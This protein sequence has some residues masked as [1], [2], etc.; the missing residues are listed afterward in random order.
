VPGTGYVVGNTLSVPIGS[1]LTIA[2]VTTGG[3]ATVT[4]TNAGSLA[5]GAVPTTRLRQQPSPASAPA[6]ILI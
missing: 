6:R 1:V 2:T 5:S 3:V 4:V